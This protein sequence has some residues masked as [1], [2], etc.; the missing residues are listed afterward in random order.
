MS[1]ESQKP[2]RAI[3]VQ[4]YVTKMLKQRLAGC[5]SRLVFVSKPR[6]PLRDEAVLNKHF[7]PLLRQLNFEIGGRHAFRHFRVSFL[8]QNGTPIEIIKPWIG[9]GSEEMIRIYTHLHC[10]GVMAKIP[11]VIPPIAPQLA[12]A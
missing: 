6:M 7:Y 12:V 9:H 4:P 5:E 2:Q 11:A 10:K 8:V 3:D 1:T